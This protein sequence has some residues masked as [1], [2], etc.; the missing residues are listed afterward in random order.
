ME[1]RTAEGLKKK[2]EYNRKYLKNNM[3]PLVIN[4]NKNTDKDILDF[5]DSLE[6]KNKYIKDLIRLNIKSKQI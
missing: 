6:N 1:K 5:L 3:K 2:A 4:L